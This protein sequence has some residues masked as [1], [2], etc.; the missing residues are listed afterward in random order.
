MEVHQNTVINGCISYALYE[1]KFDA[2]L[3]WIKAVVTIKK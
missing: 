2:A 1:N 3:L